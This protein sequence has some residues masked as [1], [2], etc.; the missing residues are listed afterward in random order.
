MKKVVHMC[1]D[2]R[3]VLNWPKKNLRGLFKKSDGKSCTSQEARDYLMDRL[4]EGKKVI[5][6]G[7]PCEGFSY[8]TGC[9][10][11]PVEENLDTSS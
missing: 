10:G 7:A 1:I 8:E 3:G 4:S 6:F 5:P 2:I 9:P 11:H